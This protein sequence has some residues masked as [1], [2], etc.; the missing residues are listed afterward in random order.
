MTAQRAHSAPNP[1]FLSPASPS[2]L[3]AGRKV[4]AQQD[5]LWPLTNSLKSTTP[6]PTEAT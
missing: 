1:V 5:H 6:T 4:Q 2:T 3:R